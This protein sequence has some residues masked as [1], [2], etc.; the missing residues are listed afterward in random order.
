MAKSKSLD[1]KLAAIHTDPSCREF[2]LADAKDADMAFGIGAPGQSPE[3]HASELGFRT[4]DEYRQLIRT[5]ARQ[6]L[7]AE[8]IQH[9][10]VRSLG[11]TCRGF[12]KPESERVQPGR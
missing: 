3:A 6:G 5:I 8:K 9:R 7:V 12:H 1:R 2:I 10:F 4:L 11:Q